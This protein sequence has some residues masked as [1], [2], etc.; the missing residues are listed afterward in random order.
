MTLTVVEKSRF[1]IIRIYGAT[2]LHSNNAADDFNVSSQRLATFE[3]SFGDE[4]NHMPDC[5]Y[6]FII[7]VY[8]KQMIFRSSINILNS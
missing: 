3:F 6:F 8:Y 4:N 7:S 5:C 2:K 1:E